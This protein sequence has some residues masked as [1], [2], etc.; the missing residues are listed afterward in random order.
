MLIFVHGLVLG[1]I[2]TGLAIAIGLTAVDYEPTPA[3]QRGYVLGSATVVLPYD[4]GQ[5]TS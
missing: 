4:G 3:A 5:A 2:A 1:A